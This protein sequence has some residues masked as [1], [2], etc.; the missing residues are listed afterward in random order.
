MI[1]RAKRSPP[2]I[3]DIQILASE[4]QYEG[5]YSFPSRTHFWPKDI[6]WNVFTNFV[7]GS[8]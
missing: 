4:V 3:P 5:S 7:S 6:M 1:S 8:T 2:W